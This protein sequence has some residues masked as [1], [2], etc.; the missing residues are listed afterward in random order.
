[1]VLNGQAHG[2][3]LLFGEHAVVHGFP[4][5]GL[6]LPLRT[7]VCLSP[8]SDIPLNGPDHASLVARLVPYMGPGALH[9]WR[10]QT[11]H[12]RVDS[13]VPMGCGLGSS[14]ALTGALAR[15]VA[16]GMTEKRPES[17]RRMAHQA[18]RH[19]HGRPSGVDTALALGEGLV[20]FH[21]IDAAVLK[22]EPCTIGPFAMVVGT[23]PRTHS[24]RDMVNHIQ[25]QLASNRDTTLA[26]LSRL[27]SL[28]V[29]PDVTESAWTLLGDRANEAH[30][31]LRS[32]GVSTPALDRALSIGR[33]AGACGG[34]LS[35]AGGGGAFVLFCKDVTC[36][37]QVELAVTQSSECHTHTY[38]WDGQ[39]L[40]TTGDKTS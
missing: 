40:V 4:A 19:F 12:V 21:R 15:A 32:L 6:T 37:R 5:L 29:L 27:G 39:G 10:S 36:A 28:A 25:D 24:T 31:L 23:L 13:N 11:W 18:E 3:L 1:M 26:R 7:Q 16:H 17:I 22:T 2:K 34:K 35:G 30:T 38:Q 20:T 8:D 14:A 33:A 9:L